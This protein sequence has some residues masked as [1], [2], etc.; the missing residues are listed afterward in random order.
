VAA[1]TGFSDANHLCKAFRK[2]F[3]TSPA[4]YRRLNKI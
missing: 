2:R 1:Q 4:I 3:Q